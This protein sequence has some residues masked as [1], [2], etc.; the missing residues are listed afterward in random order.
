MGG[1]GKFRISEESEWIQAYL[2]TNE[3]KYLAGLYERYKQQIYIQC[4]K[5][6]SNP[7]DAQDLSSETFIRAFDRIVQFKVGSPFYPW[8]NRIAMNLCIDFLRQ[9]SKRHFQQVDDLQLEDEGVS[10]IDGNEQGELKARL[11][12]EL[13][14]LKV[15]QRR[16]FCLFYINKLSYKDIAKLIGMSDNRVRSHIQNARRR[17][18]ILMEQV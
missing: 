18:K 7:V 15:E 1:T 16:C 6:V 8:L 17:L 3:S 9:Q 12:Q 5:L 2:D 13:K 10:S 4:F 11:S 14:K